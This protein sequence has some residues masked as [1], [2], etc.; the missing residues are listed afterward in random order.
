MALPP[1][2]EED[3]MTTHQAD[4]A[5]GSIAAA[6]R[7]M[8]FAYYG[9]APGMLISSMVWLAAGVATVAVSPQKAIWTLFIGGVLIHPLALVWLKAIGRPASHTP[10][11]PFG[12]LALATTFWMILMMPLAYGASRLRIEWFFPAMLLIIG[13]RYV[14]FAIMFGNRTYWACGVALALAGYALGS[15]NWSP[16]L[17][18]FTG[19]AI[20]AGFALAIFA[21]T[22]AEIAAA[23]PA[24]QP[25]AG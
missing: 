18:A 11:N 7:E 2:A 25:A 15:A 20:E 12:A 9:G 19:A 10:G 8:R 6:Q 14:T 1:T 21:T 16:G 23:G 3:A 4:F 22:R 24:L 17:G 13:G 5:V